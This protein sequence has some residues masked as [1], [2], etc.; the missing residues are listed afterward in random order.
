MSGI[1]ATITTTKKR[2][3]VRKKMLIN[4]SSIFISSF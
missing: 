1:A 3:Q 4:D 2:K